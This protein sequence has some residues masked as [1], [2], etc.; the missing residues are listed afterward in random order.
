MSYKLHP[1]TVDA[2]ESVVA[3]KRAAVADATQVAIVNVLRQK[4]GSH[5]FRTASVCAGSDHDGDP[6]LFIEAHFDLVPHPIDP[7]I[8]AGMTV[9]LQ[10]ALEG[11]GEQRFPHISYDFH[12]DQVIAATKRKRA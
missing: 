6:V 7:I 1:Q 4:L 10:K 11:I 8:I 12:D 3:L 2:G 5:G 9:A